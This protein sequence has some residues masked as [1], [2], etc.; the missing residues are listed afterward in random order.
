MYHYYALMQPED[1]KRL[2]YTLA[3]MP[4]HATLN[5]TKSH[6]LGNTSCRSKTHWVQRDRGGDILHLWPEIHDRLLNFT[7]HVC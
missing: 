7:M 3:N 5:L 6:K 2:C 4:K 1:P